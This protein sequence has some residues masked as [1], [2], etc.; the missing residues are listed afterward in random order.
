[1]NPV[2]III[3]TLTALV[4]MAVLCTWALMRYVPG[5]DP[6]PRYR[7]ELRP[8]YN[9]AQRRWERYYARVEEEDKDHA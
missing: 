5:P 7:L 2:L 9:F 8:R 3:L 1:M 4:L 6:P